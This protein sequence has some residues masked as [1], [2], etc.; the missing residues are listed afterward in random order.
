MVHQ[1]LEM[2]INDATCFTKPA[3]LHR[4]FLFAACAL[5]TTTSAASA[6]DVRVTI[7]NLAASDS[8]AFSPVVVAAHDG[9]VDLFDTGAMASAGVEDVAELGGVNMIQD[10]IAAMQAD[11]VHAPTFAT[12]GGFGPGIF[13]PGSSGFVD[14]SLDTTANRYFSFISMAVPSNDSFVGNGDP[15][16]IELFDASGEFVAQNFTLT[17]AD[18]YDAGTELN[19]LTGALYAVGQDGSLSPAENGTVHAASDLG[20]QF[21]V[22]VGEST[23]PGV[24]FN[25]VP[26]SDTPLLSFSFEVIPEPASVMLLLGSVLLGLPLIRQ[27]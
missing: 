1:R 16:G 12:M 22:F 10:E 7:E 6:V 3:G 2:E 8:V 4:R 5:L 25:S 27:R 13:V 17:G 21:D 20:A 15:L 18:I 11:A 24:V 23:P 9:S 26:M 14:L 19:G